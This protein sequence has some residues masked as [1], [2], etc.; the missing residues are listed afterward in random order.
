MSVDLDNSTYS[1]TSSSSQ[2]SCL[3]DLQQFPGAQAL[4]WVSS[5]SQAILSPTPA[6]APSPATGAE[7]SE[8]QLT[9]GQGSPEAPQMIAE[10]QT[11]YGRAI[12]S[13]A[14]APLSPRDFNLDGWADLLWSNFVTNRNG[15]WFLN[16]TTYQSAAFLP[17][18]PN[19][20]WRLQGADDFNADGRTDTLWRDQVT[21][22]VF[23]WAMS[24]M[25]Y[26]G[27]PVSLGVVSDF[28]WQIQATGDVNGD[29][30]A[31]LVWRNPVTGQNGLG[32]LNST[33]AWIALPDAPGLNLKIAG[34]GDINQDGS[35]D[36]VWQ[37][38]L[39][40]E[41]LVWL[42][43]GVSI[44]GTIQL[45]AE[46]DLNWKLQ[47]IRDFN[48][49]GIPDLFWR[50]TS[51]Q[52]RIW[53][54]NGTS[55]SASV[56][57]Q[58]SADL[59]WQATA[60]STSTATAGVDISNFSF[61]GKEGDAGKFSLRL[62]QA[63]TSNVT[64][65]LSPGNFLVVDADGDMR[66]GMQNT[67]TF[68]PQDWNVTR[69]VSFIAEVDG[70]SENRM[71]GNLISYSLTGGLT[72][73]GTYE[74]GSITNTYAPDPTRFNIDLDFRNDYEG[75]WTPARRAIAQKAANDW[76]AR[77]AN[78]WSD[79]ALNHIIGRLDNGQ[80][81]RPYS[82]TTR[83]YVDDLVVFVNNFTGTSA[84]EGGYGLADYGFGGYSE[85]APMPRVGQLT[86]N[87]AAFVNQPDSFLYQIVSHEIG[88]I[89]GLVGLNWIGASLLANTSTPAIATFQGEFARVANGGQ[90]VP[91]ESQDGPNPVT[92]TYG[93]AHPANS[94]RSIMSY[95]W[96][97]QSSA[98][99]EIDYAMLADS[100]YLVRGYNA[101]IVT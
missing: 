43:N 51:G 67:I 78:E 39:S 15:V 82:F 85:A 41:S 16:G 83:R 50:S 72:A 36:I 29:R 3:S 62:T 11:I 49:D 53:L 68:T 101:P 22:E 55:V 91:L 2:A 1:F 42:T 4:N 30:R 99:T 73:S 47:D 13:P 23:F 45:A 25:S 14:P 38:T 56:L 60:L 96:L 94:V 31:D 8:P 33:N 81:A 65:T 61:S 89:L 90:Y 5:S 58:P 34:T 27:S 44:T 40:N 95:G 92:G 7:G 88:H 100:G 59:N 48:R 63:P 28:N 6:A 12:A 64:L 46:P 37:N 57:T 97:Y 84:T 71:M 52:N 76:A 86:I 24:G 74:L 80:A 19:S 18:V 87:S 98:P 10:S 20:N 26:S 77:I 9:P 32:I 54:M 70:S 79:F 35:L 69:T 66:N 93:Y 21:G 17:N 75:F